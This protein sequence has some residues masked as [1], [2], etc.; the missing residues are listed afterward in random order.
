MKQIIYFLVVALSIGCS[1]VRLS[2]GENYSIRSYKRMQLSNGM[3]LILIRDNSLPTIS[4]QMRVNVGLKDDPQ[5]L[6]GLTH[7]TG[8]L[9][10][11]GTSKMDDA[12]MADAF[13]EIGGEFDTITQNEFTLINAAS[14]SQYNDRLLEL[15]VESVQSPAFSEKEIEKNRSQTLAAIQKF[16]ENPSGY[17]DYL[18]M[19]E[20]FKDHPFQNLNIGTKESVSKIKRT[21]IVKQFFR[22]F[23]PNNVSLAVVGNF[24]KDFQ[25]KLIEIFAGW[26][27]QEIN[28]EAE[29]IPAALDKLNYI[30]VT[31]SG[32]EQTQIRYQLKGI[33]RNHPEFLPLRLANV[34][35]GGSFASR[36]NQKIRDDLGLT[37]NISSSFNF[38]QNFGSYSVS[39]FT[40]NDK[41][42]D[43]LVETNK[44]LESFMAT[45]ITE[46]ELDAAKALLIGQFPA[47]IETSEKLG[48]TLLLLDYYGVEDGY[49]DQ[50]VRKVKK[51]KLAE[52]NQAIKNN[53]DFAKMNITIFADQEKIKSQTGWIKDLK[54]IK[55]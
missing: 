34:V 52:V 23:R 55:F 21:D 3:N 4:L 38:F 36:L 42:K 49:L 46:K 22:F 30:L 10:D 51:I 6:P 39:T 32:L 53:L 2:S 24:E 9:L 43:T 5:N 13:A 19:K 26:K 54:T 37:Y 41:V 7:F 27:S 44:M 8:S 12:Q 48:S 29:K 35:L 40:R 18:S 1:S 16:V 25:K 11:Q 31:K 45:G 14:L 47:V 17:A 15:F 50:F 33:P 28:R 20:Y